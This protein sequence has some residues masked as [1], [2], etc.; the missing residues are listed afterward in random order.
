MLIAYFFVHLHVYLKSILM[1]TMDILLF[2]RISKPKRYQVLFSSL[3]DSSYERLMSQKRLR[4]NLDGNG[5]RIGPFL[6]HTTQTSLFLSIKTPEK[7]IIS[8][9]Y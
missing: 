6:L 9:K 5:V 2:H 4:S 1:F 3:K 8:V 7:R